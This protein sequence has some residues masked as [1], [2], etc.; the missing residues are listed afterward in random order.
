V[1]ARTAGDGDASGSDLGVIGR[2]DPEGDSAAG[3]F[4]GVSGRGEVFGGSGEESYT[5][6]STKKTR[7][8]LLKK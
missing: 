2:G 6:S 5:T 3:G 7:S 1:T 8:K 4:T